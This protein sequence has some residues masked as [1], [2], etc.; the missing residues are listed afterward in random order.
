MKIG[1]IVEPGTQKFS[2]I[3]FGLK[4]NFENYPQIRYSEFKTGFCEFVNII[5]YKYKT[6]CRRLKLKREFV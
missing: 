1:M 6:I 2:G 4:I 5:D 3:V